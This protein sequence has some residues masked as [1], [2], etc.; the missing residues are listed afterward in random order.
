MR[1]RKILYC[2]S[3]DQALRTRIIIIIILFGRGY[4]ELILRLWE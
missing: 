1:R 4:T 3:K 2:V